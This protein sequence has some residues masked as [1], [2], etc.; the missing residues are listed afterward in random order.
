M[1]NHPSQD[2]K[3]STQPRRGRKPNS[4][5]RI[6]FEGK[7]YISLLE[8]A[9]IAGVTSSTMY[10]WSERGTTGDGKPLHFIQD[11]MSKQKF[12]ALESAQHLANRFVVL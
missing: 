4:H 1:S 8:A 11:K 10:N 5:R 12:I 9:K 3:T 6:T 7:V 2:K